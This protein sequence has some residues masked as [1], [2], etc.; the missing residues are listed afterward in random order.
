LH[1]LQTLTDGYKLFVSYL[2][3]TPPKPITM[4][5]LFTLLFSCLL[6]H[7]IAQ[8]NFLTISY[9]Q[10]QSQSSPTL[11]DLAV[12]NENRIFVRTDSTYIYENS[13]WHSD[14]VLS[15]YYPYSLTFDQ[16]NDG[17]FFQNNEL[18]HYSNNAVNIVSS[19]SSVFTT[20]I[21]LDN[22]RIHPNGDIWMVG[23]YSNGDSTVII[24]YNGIFTYYQIPQLANQMIAKQIR[25][26]NSGKLWILTNNDS[27]PLLFDNGN[28][29]TSVVRPSGG[30]TPMSWDF[31]FDTGGNIWLRGN[32]FTTSQSGLIKFDGTVFTD[33][34]YSP[35]TFPF[36]ENELE[37]SASNDV[38]FINNYYF[39]LALF[40]GSFTNLFS[41]TPSPLNGHR[42]RTGKNGWLYIYDSN[43]FS[44][45]SG[46]ITVYSA[47]GFNSINGNTFLDANND[48]VKQPTELTIS[49]LKVSTLPSVFDFSDST[50]FH[51][52]LYDTTGTYTV[53]TNPPLY[54]HLSNS[55]VTYSVVQTFSGEQTQNIDFGF[56]ADTVIDDVS[57]QLLISTARRGFDS[58]GSFAIYN[59]GTT[60]VSDTVKLILPNGVSLVSSDIPALNITGNLITWLN[61]QLQPF[62]SFRNSFIFHTDTSLAVG[63]PIIFQLHAGPFPDGNIYNNNIN[64]TRLVVASFDPNEKTVDYP[65]ADSSGNITGNEELTYTIFFQNT[66]TDTAFTVVVKDTISSFLDISTLR[67]LSSSHPYQFAY[68]NGQLQFNFN[69]IMLPD[70]S[71]DE[72]HSHGY[73][74]YAVKPLS[75]LPNASTIENTGYIYFDFN[76]P[77]ITNTTFNAVTIT[78]VGEIK[79]EN[80]IQIYPQPASDWITFNIESLKA[81][82]I[83]SATIKDLMGRSIE[84][85]NITSTQFSF[86]ASKLTSGLYIIEMSGDEQRSYK[87]MVK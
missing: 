66:G 60:T 35:V 40:N 48:G 75:G 24:K 47:N 25:F 63:T 3:E 43:Q 54:W 84:T 49:N 64:I 38:Y 16:N 11:Y 8:N 51:I 6:L 65:N 26:D 44:S 56:S 23:T 30:M 5:A 46:I 80:E 34:P 70:S 87:F 36:P 50:G 17:W 61:P 74:S 12:D 69:N 10:P 59:V 4:K 31:E 52:N 19:F 22:L 57:V 72:R 32:D 15:A 7:S 76:S 13:V 18:A 82:Y 42:L 39:D 53:S 28:G 27:I 77:V 62:Q 81:L 85:F 58:Y 45:S 73:V 83:K 55:P 78:S 71:T 21:G 68:H 1:R 29:F 79:N 20:P 86:N 2:Y 14:T 37:I 33:Y 67:L 41:F 9:P